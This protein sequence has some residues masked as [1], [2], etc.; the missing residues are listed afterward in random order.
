MSFEDIPEDR[1]ESCP[2]PLCSGDITY[3]PELGWVCNK[4]DWK[5]EE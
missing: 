3:M 2:C 5:P 4:C 1:E